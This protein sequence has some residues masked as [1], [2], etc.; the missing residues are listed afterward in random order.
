MTPPAISVY[1]FELNNEQFYVEGICA[2]LYTHFNFH[3]VP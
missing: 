1:T 3:F 2:P